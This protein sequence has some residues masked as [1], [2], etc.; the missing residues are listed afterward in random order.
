MVTVITY[1]TFDLF[2]YGHVRLLQRMSKLGDRLVVGCSSDEFNAMKG[3]ESVMSYQERVEILMSCR[4]VDSVFPEN[5]WDQ[6]RIDIARE[7]A[8]IFSM[9][10]DWEGKFDD[11]KDIVEVIYLS[12]TAGVST[13]DL[14]GKVVKKAADKQG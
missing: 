4:Y 14:R 10:S 6:K 9:G 5:T 12:R 8:D 2:H 1:G 3:K 13:T 11:L 7:N